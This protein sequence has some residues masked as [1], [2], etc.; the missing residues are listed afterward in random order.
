[1]TTQEITNTYLTHLNKLGKVIGTPLD[2]D[3]VFPLMPFILAD[4]VYQI[5]KKRIA[6]IPGKFEMARM[7]KLWL[8]HYNKFNKEFFASFSPDQVDAVVDYMDEFQETIANQVEIFRIEILD[9]CPPA[10]SLDDKMTLSYIMLADCLTWG[11][12]G[13]WQECYKKDITPFRLQNTISYTTKADSNIDLLQMA[14]AVHTLIY[15]FCPE[16]KTHR[17]DSMDKF[18]KLWDVICHKTIA[19]VTKKNQRT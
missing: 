18:Y 4:M 6:P 3:S 11:A 13:C 7:K 17:V 8:M 9:L 15:L 2:Q 10:L 14:K 16:M 5:Y 12:I 1:M 19:Y